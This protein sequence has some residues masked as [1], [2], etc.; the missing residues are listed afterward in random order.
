MDL[1]YA[2][3]QGK[4]VSNVHNIYLNREFANFQEKNFSSNFFFF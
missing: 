2:S 3:F 4:N 1:V